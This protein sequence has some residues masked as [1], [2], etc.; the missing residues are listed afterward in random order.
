MRWRFGVGR[1][2]AAVDLRALLAARM[3]WAPG[4]LWGL[5][6]AR[7][8]VSAGA[9]LGAWV[10]CCSARPNIARADDRGLRP[11]FR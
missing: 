3:G 11:V 1:R 8:G 10:F 7:A 5:L 6:R 9:G 2:W 4:W